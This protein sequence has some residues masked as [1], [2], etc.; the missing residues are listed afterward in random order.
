MIRTVL[1]GVIAVAAFVAAPAFAN[2]D[3]DGRGCRSAAAQSVDISRAEAIQIARQ[4]GL[5][6]VEG[7]ELDDHDCEIE[8]RT[9]NRRGIEIETSARAG[10]VLGREIDD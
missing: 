3:D 10:E 2:D 4:H 1:A 7:I 5:R 6:H 9:S 8:R